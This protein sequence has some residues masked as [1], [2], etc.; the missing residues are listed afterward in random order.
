MQRAGGGVDPAHA[1]RQQLRAA[2]LRRRPG[3]VEQPV[4][5]D[6]RPATSRRASSTFG[7]SCGGRPQRAPDFVDPQADRSAPTPRRP[8]PA[9]RIVETNDNGIVVRG[10]KSLGTVAPFADWIHIGVFFRPGIAGDQIIYARCPAN[11]KGVTIV[12][13]ES[14]VKDD[15]VEHPLASQ[16]D[17][18]D[19]LIVFEDVL[20]PVEARLPHRQ[21]RARA[22]LPAARVR[23]GALPRAGPPG[24]ARR[25][26]GGPGPA[27]HRAHRHRAHRGGDRRGSPSWSASTRRPTRTSSRPR[28]Q[29]F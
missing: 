29:G 17:E 25:A 7:T 11:A 21:P 8:S 9:L 20:D 12:C 28:H 4:G 24:G 3:A 19:A 5:R 1:G 23:L 14:M 2:D 22:A 27:D 6:R 15:P 16:G 26:D 10:V 13:R 18:L